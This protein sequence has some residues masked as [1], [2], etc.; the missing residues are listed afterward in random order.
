MQRRF[1]YL[2]SM[3][4]AALLCTQLAACTADGSIYSSQPWTPASSVSSTT[5]KLPAK[6]HSAL[7]Q[8]ATHIAPATPCNTLQLAGNAAQPSLTSTHKKRSAL[9]APATH[10]QSAQS[11]SGKIVLPVTVKEQG[12]LQHHGTIPT[13]SQ[14]PANTPLHSLLPGAST[15]PSHIN[16]SGQSQ[17]PYHNPSQ[18]NK[19]RAKR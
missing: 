19:A 14:L 16:A 17:A 15:A 3:I 8:P 12:K 9:P 13:K 1:V 4:P 2:T 7:L 10:C 11:I 5:Q 6:I 18:P